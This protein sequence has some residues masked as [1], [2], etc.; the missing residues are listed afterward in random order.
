[1]DRAAAARRP[2]RRAGRGH[3]R[4]GR[5]GP[6]RCVRARRGRAP[7]LAPG[8]D[9]ARRRPARAL[10]RRCLV[11]RGLANRP[12]RGRP[13]ALG[14]SGVP[15]RPRPALGRADLQGS[16]PLGRRRARG[17]Q[18]L[19]HQP[20]NP[21]GLDPDST[22]QPQGDPPKVG[23][24]MGKLVLDAIETSSGRLYNLSLRPNGVYVQPACLDQR[25]SRTRPRNS[26]SAA[27]GAS[28]IGIPSSATASQSWP[29][30]R[31]TTSSRPSCSTMRPAGFDSRPSSPAPTGLWPTADG[32]LWL[33]VQD[34]L[35]YRS[36]RGEWFAVPSP[37]GTS[38]LS[39][40][41]GSAT[42]R[43]CG[44][45]AGSATRP[46]CS[47]P[48]ESSTG[49]GGARRDALELAIRLRSSACGVRPRVCRTSTLSTPRSSSA[50]SSAINA[51]RRI[52]KAS[53][54]LTRRRSATPASA[55]PRSGRATTR[56]PPTT[57]GCGSANP[58]RQSRRRCRANGRAGRRSRCA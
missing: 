35:R 52:S 51:S 58:R 14:V 18:G 22:R 53:R 28:P 30:S 24:R 2:Q 27:T 17:T 32:G 42:S 57:S 47:R 55:R 11:R 13:P 49:G 38:K 4:C 3:D 20:A 16:D 44:C 12:R 15:A 43:P 26:R 8:R 19:V 41:I 23:L 9:R 34:Q 5:A 6:D 37:P 39:A 45:S 50:T 33:L 36:A 7:G 40:A 46:C 10:A 21:R 31:S 48:P 56:P 29:P 1:M 25:S 54:G